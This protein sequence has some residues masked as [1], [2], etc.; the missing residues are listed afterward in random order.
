MISQGL[1]YKKGE[2]R[3]KNGG[4]L[5]QVF[6]KSLDSGIPRCDGQPDESE[7]A[8]CVVPFTRQPELRTRL[9]LKLLGYRRRVSCLMGDDLKEQEGMHRVCGL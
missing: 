1:V 2:K 5:T 3:G 4:F 7:A 6:P 8:R 9:A